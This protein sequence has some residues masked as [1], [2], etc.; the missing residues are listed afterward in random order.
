M[1]AR[2]GRRKGVRFALRFARDLQAISMKKIEQR[3]RETE[4]LGKM[5]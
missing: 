1:H 5:N 3:E 2:H 4:A